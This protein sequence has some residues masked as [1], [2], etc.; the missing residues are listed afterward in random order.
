VKIACLSM[1]SRP[2]ALDRRGYA[3]A[4]P[5]PHAASGHCNQVR[6]RGAIFVPLNFYFNGANIA[7]RRPLSAIDRSTGNA[8]GATLRFSH[9]AST[10]VFPATRILQNSGLLRPSGLRSPHGEGGSRHSPK[11]RCAHGSC[12]SDGGSISLRL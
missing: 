8:C 6:K 2:L 1:I 7:P 3:E 9:S 11:C 12:E 10:L 5:R 4:S